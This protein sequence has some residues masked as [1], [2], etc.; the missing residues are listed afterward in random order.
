MLLYTKNF[1]TI[2]ENYAKRKRSLVEI[3]V[4]LTDIIKYFDMEIINY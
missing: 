4:P 3:D 1:K 2:A